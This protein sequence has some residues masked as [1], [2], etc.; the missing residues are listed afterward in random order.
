MLNSVKSNDVVMEVMKNLLDFCGKVMV[1]NLCIGHL[2]EQV[3][4]YLSL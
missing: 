1:D 4:F 2:V 3:P